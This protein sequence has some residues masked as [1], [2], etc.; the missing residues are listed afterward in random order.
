M[1]PLKRGMRSNL[2]RTC[3]SCVGLFVAFV[4]R[5]CGFCL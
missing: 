4:W 3:S 1:G 2:Q 5:F